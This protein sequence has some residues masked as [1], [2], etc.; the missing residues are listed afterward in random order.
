M[1]C[2]LRQRENHAKYALCF[3]KGLF[4]KKKTQT[5]R[6]HKTM[7]QSSI[8]SCTLTRSIYYTLLLSHVSSSNGIISNW[9]C[10]LKEASMCIDNAGQVLLK[11]M[12][13]M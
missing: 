2:C 13:F 3:W 7:H 4:E 8:E 6:N 12:I 5:T 11:R 1:D 9:G 10:N